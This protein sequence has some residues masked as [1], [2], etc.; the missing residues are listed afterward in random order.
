[1][2]QNQPRRGLDG[3]G[4]EK[5]MGRTLVEF[6]GLLADML[7]DARDKYDARPG[8]G[9]SGYL[10]DASADAV[11][12][13]RHL[14]HVV[15]SYANGADKRGI[16]PGWGAFWS[17]G[18]DRPALLKLIARRSRITRAVSNGGD[19]DTMLVDDSVRYWEYGLALS[20]MTD[21][22]HLLAAHRCKKTEAV[23]RIGL[24]LA[25]SVTVVAAYTGL[26]AAEIQKTVEDCGTTR[27][28]YPGHG[29]DGSRTWEPHPLFDLI[30]AN[31]P[32][33]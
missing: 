8:P 2:E 26:D 15:D 29:P 16:R 3:K 28:T 22:D 20:M 23:R 14:A 1:M 11:T 12:A 27:P 24:E 18:M 5:I 17:D 33:V 4:E 32:T 21:V 6:H 31:R 30:T 7:T 9:E 25:L 19:M 10:N 13:W